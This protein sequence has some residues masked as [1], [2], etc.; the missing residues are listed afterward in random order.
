[1]ERFGKPL[2]SLLAIKSSYFNDNDALAAYQDELT[3]LYV[4]QPRRDRCVTCDHSM[5]DVAAIHIRGAAYGTCP[6]CGHFNGLHQD[7]E[8]YGDAVYGSKGGA[9]YARPYT[10]QG[11][12]DYELRTAEIYVPKAAFLRDALAEQGESLGTMDCIDLG[13]GSGYFVS[14]LRQVGVGSIRGFDPSQAQTA[15]A[16]AMLGPGWVER[17]PPER[18]AKVA[19][20][21]AGAVVSMIGVLE[22]L[23]DG[24]A[25]MRALAENPAVRYLYLCLP[26]VGPSVVIEALFPQVMRRHL[27]GGHTHL[28]SDSSI[29]WLC[30]EFGF[31]RA[32]EWWFGSDMM[33]LY[34]NVAVALVKD[35]GAAGLA[36]MWRDHMVPALDGLQLALD[37]RKLCSEVHLLLRKS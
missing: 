13:A 19:A 30:R 7:T 37:Q 9:A 5:A 23:P 34:R 20:S 12:E 24:R 17:H 29:D 16:E 2:G 10:A 22:H 26:L 8:A 6:R 27:V 36:A 14:A 32:S 18:I 35:E 33:D 21:R 3:R 25:V 28:Y 4:A 15:Q 11:R 1:M 31:T